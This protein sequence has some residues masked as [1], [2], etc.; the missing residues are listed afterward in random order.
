MP[1]TPPS[2]PADRQREPKRILFVEANE[3]GTVGGSHKALYD[4]VRLIDRRRFEPLVLFYQHNEYIG[5]LRDADVEA[6]D[7]EDVRRGERQ[8]RGDS[9]VV[10]KVGGLLARI[11]QRMRFL[12]AHRI[13]LV[14][15]NNSPKVGSDD[16][17]PA[18]RLLRI[19]CLV[20]VMG[21]ARGDTGRVRKWLFRQ[22]DHYLPISRFIADA[23]EG[24]GIPRQKMD[25]I[26]LGVDVEAIRSGVR[27]SRGEVRTEL[28]VPDGAVLALMI[29]NI[30]EWKGQHVVLDAFARLEGEA[31][32]RLHIAFAGAAGAADVPYQQRLA[33]IVARAKLEERVHFLGPRSDVPDLL[34]AADIALHASIRPEPFGLVVIEAMAAGRTLIAANTGGPAEIVEEGT[35]FTFDPAEPA[36]LASLLDRLVRD[37]AQVNAVGHRAGQRAE[38]FSIQAYTAG[39]QRVY[40]RMLGD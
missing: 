8:V 28:G 37:P 13:D 17:L 30:R 14:H 38:A 20:N 16:W 35:G 4:L 23:M 2:R 22:F 33:D 3:D 27:K 19:P 32:E 1:S 40:E 5:R 34:A 10:V 24:H 25:L 21:D 26:Y 11:R 9:N 39:V 12:R 15:L 29:G 31:R 6:L 18:A 36:Q 7:F